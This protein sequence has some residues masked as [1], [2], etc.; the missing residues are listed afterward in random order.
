MENHRLME[1]SRNDHR[2]IEASRKL[3]EALQDNT[4]R[5]DKSIIA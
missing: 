1:A 4:S 3:I 2:I 5:V